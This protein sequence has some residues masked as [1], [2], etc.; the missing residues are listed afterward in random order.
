MTLHALDAFRSK[1]G[2]NGEEVLLKAVDA[3][4][5]AR[6]IAIAERNPTQKA[7]IYGWLDHRLGQV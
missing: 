4:Q 3:L 7:F 6:Y 2:P 5:G 1:R